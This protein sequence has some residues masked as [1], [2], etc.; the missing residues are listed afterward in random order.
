MVRIIAKGHEDKCIPTLLYD[1]IDNVFSKSEE[2]M[3]DLRAAL[4][5]GYRRNAR[6]TRC[7][8]KGDGVV[9]FPS[10][11]QS[12]GASPR[13]EYQGDLRPHAPACS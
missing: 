7:I 13:T 3:S 11:A 10:Y 1:E 4:N 5:A 9:D 6:S 8:N 12:Q 2:G